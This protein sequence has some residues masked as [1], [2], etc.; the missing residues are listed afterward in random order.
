MKPELEMLKTKLRATWTAGD[1]S[2]IAKAYTKGAEQFVDRLQ[3]KPGMTFLDVA[4]GSGN[5]TGQIAE[6]KVWDTESGQE[7]LNLKGD[8]YGPGLAFSPNGHWLISHAPG[9]MMIYD[10]TPLP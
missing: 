6:V 5:P 2:Q 8:G 7:L 4:C 9:K 3:L 10:A 1:F